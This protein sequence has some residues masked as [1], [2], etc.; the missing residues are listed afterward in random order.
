M[1]A[2]AAP[3]VET[4]AEV[5]NRVDEELRAEMIECQAQIRRWTTEQK[6]IVDSLTL[7]AQRT[8]EGD[9]ENLAQKKEELRAI[10]SADEALQR[11]T[12]EQNAKLDH[13]RQEL[14]ALTA[15]ESML[16]LERAKLKKALDQQ[17][18]L[19]VEREMALQQMQAGKDHKLA[20]L[21]KG[22]TMYR[23]MLG[24]EFER[25]GDERLRLVMTS[26]DARAPSRAFSFTV[27]VDSADRYHIEHCDPMVPMLATLVEKLNENNDFS[28]FVR[29]LRHEFK[30]LC[31]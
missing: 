27:Y 6:H 23:N 22:C 8:L 30:R 15:Q 1:A 31:T 17:R 13:L 28:L 25:I 2:V 26:I 5:V 11:S 7:D 20:E 29:S 3:P 16:P 19:L 18:Q 4:A 21:N 9:K 14:D 12:K 10:L 24:L